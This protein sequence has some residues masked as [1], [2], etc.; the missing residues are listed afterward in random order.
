MSKINEV[1]SKHGFF[2]RFFEQRNI[3]RYLIKKKVQGKNKMTRN[4]PS[5]VLEKFNGYETIR[6][7]LARKG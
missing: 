6:N 3:H 7:D 5:F 2:I 1:I 4:L